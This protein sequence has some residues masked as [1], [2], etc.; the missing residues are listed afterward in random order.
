MCGA[1]ARMIYAYKVSH[2]META[3]Q[4]NA[5]QYIRTEIKA[6]FLL[7]GGYCV[8]ALLICLCCFSVGRNAFYCKAYLIFSSAGVYSYV[9]WYQ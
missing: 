2:D 6:T 7:F 8:K 9:R 3:V 5:F 4:S 1:A